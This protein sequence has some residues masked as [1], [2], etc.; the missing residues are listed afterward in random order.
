MEGEHPSVPPRASSKATI[1]SRQLQ[2]KQSRA[3]I[4]R[5]LSELSYEETPI[6]Y[7]KLKIEDLELQCEEQ[8][9]DKSRLDLEYEQYQLPNMDHYKG[10]RKIN[11]RISSLR[12]EL[13][14]Q[15]EALR[16]QEE[17]E[18][19]VPKLGS[20]SRGA[21]N[22]TLLA[23]YKDPYHS[24]KRSTHIQSQM[25]K[26][27]ITVY[28]ARKDAP[29]EDKICCCITRRYYD[30]YNI[31]AVHIVPHALGPELV[32]YIFGTGSGLRLDTAD[33]CLLMHQDV[34]RSFGNG[35]FVLIPVDA[36]ESPILRWRIQMTNLAAIDTDL[37]RVTLGDVDGKEVLFKNN[38]RPA[39]RF[40]YYHFVM[41]L[42]RNKWYRQPGWEKYWVELPTGRPFA[43][44]G[45]YVR[46]SMLL[47][48]AKEAGDLNAAEEARLLGGEGET[49]T[50]EQKLSEVEEAEVAR[51]A[52]KAH[53]V[54]DEDDYS[55]SE[56]DY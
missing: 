51:R 49:F 23:L 52:L 56:D 25:K 47:A 54:R 16:G 41:T 36:S 55:S 24:H 26:T 38:N 22:S 21:F 2:L 3:E 7:L 37:G 17:K 13:W 53:E 34:E 29:S 20:D 11:E 44:M 32:D 46:E 4:E 14:T 15:Q 39:A 10:E 50:E 9:V 48:L 1:E 18:G 6:P 43:A 28:A 8:R 45:P 31:R 33:N 40:L 12:N 42:L 27:S 30:R 35:N 19:L 5:K